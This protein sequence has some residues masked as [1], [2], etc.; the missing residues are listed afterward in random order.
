MPARRSWRRILSVVLCVHLMPV[1]GSPAVSSF[2]NRS[3]SAITWGV[4]FPRPCVRHRDAGCD[5]RAGLLRQ[6]PVS[7]W[8]WYERR[9]PSL[10]PCVCLLPNRAASTQGRQT[11]GAAAH[12]GDRGRAR[13]PPCSGR[14]PRLVALAPRAVRPS[15]PASALSSARGRNCN[16]D[17]PPTPSRA[18][19][20]AL[21]PVE[22]EA[23]PPPRERL[24]P[25]PPRSTHL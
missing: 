23:R 25:P 24:P 20:A 6:V 21:E 5:R 12:R 4:F 1:M 7:P 13:S 15:E 3:I 19:G 8:R 17:K 11:A 18:R 2:I 9:D 14:G 10:R 16:R 22:A